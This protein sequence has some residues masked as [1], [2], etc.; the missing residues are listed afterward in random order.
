MKKV[1][2]FFILMLLPMVAGAE[3]VEIDGIYYNLVSDTKEAE[4]TYMPSGYYS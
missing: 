1:L 3:T 2:S 4:V